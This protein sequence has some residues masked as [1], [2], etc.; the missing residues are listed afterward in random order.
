[1]SINKKPIPNR[2]YNASSDHP[3]VAGVVTIGIAVMGYLAYPMFID[4]F[5]KLKN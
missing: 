5:N 1:M 4:Y 3:Y 2:I